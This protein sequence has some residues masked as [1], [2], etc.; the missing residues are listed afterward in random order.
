MQGRR[1]EPVST[2]DEL[3]ESEARFWALV[4]YS[5]DVIT[6]LAPDGRVQYNTPAVRRVL[7][8]EPAELRGR[9]AFEFVHPDDRE[10]VMEQFGVALA[11]PG[12]P[13]PVTF[14][15]RHRRG[16]WVPLE[17]IGSNQLNDPHVNGIVVNSRDITERQ[18]VEE[19]LRQS[20]HLYHLLMEQVPVGILF[21]DAGG[22]ITT[23]NPAVLAI[24]GSP[25]EEATRQF[26]V[27][28]LPP[29]EQAGLRAVYRRVLLEHRVERAD[30]SYRSFW[31]KT[32]DV[33]LVIAPLF[34]HSGQLL[35]SVT[36]A[37]DVTERTRADRERKALLEEQAAVSM[38][39]AR[40]GREL[41]SALNNSD[42][43]DRLCE[44]T[45]RVLGCDRSHTLLLDPEERVYRVA[46]GFGDPPEDPGVIRAARYPEALAAS[47]LARLQTEDVTQLDRDLDAALAEL[48]ARHGVRGQ[49]YMAL[50]RGEQIIGLHTASS[51]SERAHFTPQQE[52]IARGIAQLG[53]LAL[54]DA[55]LVAELGRANRLKS[56]FVATMSHELRTPL[57][58][59]IGYHSLLL[60]GT[61][62][63]LATE[64]RDAVARADRNARALLELISATL[65]MSR[66][67]S[68]QLPLDLR[69]FELGDLLGDVDAETREL[70]L[71]RAPAVEVRW[72]PLPAL[73]PLYSDPAKLKVVLKNLLG[74]AA[75]FT[76]QGIIAISAAPA[77]DGV[78]IAVRDT[79]AGIP[80][81]LLPVIFEPF[82]QAG[83]HHHG[84]V[85]LGLY[86]VQRL[87]AELGGSVDVDSTPGEGSTFRIWLPLRR[88]RPH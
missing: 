88:P 19:S 36:I 83:G 29:L 73:R 51:F 63:A 76:E 41:I 47:V 55:R 21:T 7:G 75:K 33:R 28:H 85:G 14:R 49:M 22:Q 50:R 42:L 40:V 11:H 27:L 1:V 87:M 24:L 37:E 78:E 68:G 53:S 31:G 60:D 79:G 4:Q 52:Q 39:M 81:E 5:S 59:I 56:E 44:T 61:F 54:E 2:P 15:F 45:A 43:L 62:G 20:Q 72:H 17:A 80:R 64:Q 48:H 46:A 58:I 74:N 34:D 8:Y 3:S 12:A 70:Q 65:D 10:H 82:R 77:G 32:A 13:I 71:Q 30:V 23:A 38:A 35:G 86:I 26:N 84:G 16:H 25:S 9:N 18:R 6:V 66:L 57:N 69:E 67:E